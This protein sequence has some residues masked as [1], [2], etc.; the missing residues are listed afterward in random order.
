M[1]HP[2]RHT[3]K[4]T[5]QRLGHLSVIREQ[6]VVEQPGDRFG[7]RLRGWR[8][9][10]EGGG[11]MGIGRSRG[12]NLRLGIRAAGSGAD[13]SC[14]GVAGLVLLPRFGG[15]DLV[16]VLPGQMHAIKL[17]RKPQPVADVAGIEGLGIR[18]G[19]PHPPLQQFEQGFEVS[20]FRSGA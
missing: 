17:G 2:Q 10:G 11:Q 1:A 18:P 13:V 3:F 12:A 14:L 15:T 6:V 7:R 8:F 16:C 19:Q 20:H 9:G 4:A 5:L